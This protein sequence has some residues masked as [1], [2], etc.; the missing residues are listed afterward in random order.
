VPNVGRDSFRCF[1]GLLAVATIA[2]GVAP[3]CTFCDGSVCSDIL[4]V[5]ARES[6][7]G[8]LADGEYVIDVVLD[9]APD[10]GTCVVSQEGHEIDC[11]GLATVIQAPLYDSPDNPHT[12]LEL[13]FEAGDPGPEPPDQIAVTITHD[14][15]VVLD[16]AFEPD[17]ELAKP[18]KCDSDCVHATHAFAFT[19]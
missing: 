16:E 3:G 8:A 7:G 14:G 6:G 10:S 19:R 1:L 9:G 2:G 18:K 5:Y 13:Y 12:V 17:Y 15:A 4:W 11:D